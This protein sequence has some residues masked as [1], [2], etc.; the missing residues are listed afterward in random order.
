[1][2]FDQPQ[3]G[4]IVVRQQKTA[5]ISPGFELIKDESEGARHIKPFPCHYQGSID[6]NIWPIVEMYFL[7]HLCPGEFFIETVTGAS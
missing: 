6:F 1:M 3:A 2:E 4:W 5:Q 7:T